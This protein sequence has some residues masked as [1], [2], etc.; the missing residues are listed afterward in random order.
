MFSP[1]NIEN[2]QEC[3]NFISGKW[4]LPEEKMGHITS[5]FTGQ[6]I[7][8]TYRSKNATVNSAVLSA[9]K[10]QQEW[11]KYSYRDRAAIFLNY[12]KWLIENLTELAKIISN[13][14]GK[15]P[16]EAKDGLLKG[17]E[18]L[19]YAVSIQN[20]DQLGKMTV[21]KG[22]QCEYRREPLGVVAG[23]TPSN[24]P[25][26]VPMWMFPIAIMVGNSFIWKPSE[27][28]AMTAY[29]LAQ[30]FKEAGLPDG[31]LNVIQGDKETVDLLCDHENIKAIAFV[32]STPV[33]KHVYTKATTSGKRALT[34]GGAKNHIFLMPD[35]INE[36]AVEG[37]LSSFTG[38]CGQRCMAASVLLAIG[39]TQKII[40][41]I[42]IKAK[43][44]TPGK[45]IGALITKQS[46]Q[47]VEK[48]ISTASLNKEQILVDGR[49][50]KVEKELSLGNWL[51]PTI[52]DY[53]LPE[54]ILAKEELFAP[55]LSIIRCKNIEEAMQIENANPY[56]NAASVFTTRGDIAEFV[57]L[58]A[59]AGMIGINVGIPVPR[60]PFS[61]GGINHSKFGH[62]D[63][64][65]DGG[66][67][68]WSNRKKVTTKWFQIKNQNWMS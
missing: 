38:C 62:G 25:A 63:I 11:E 57:T 29:Y 50:P 27:K 39:D 44:F 23:I 51:N 28:T 42:I 55:V 5:P 12:R 58:N 20:L 19:D 15:L 3:L 24:F 59:R 10:S 35:A 2:I 8:N 14:C 4:E 21:S 18:I 37:I 67:E 65:S 22:V 1:N 17:I 33:A 46:L 47:K 60:E 45:D 52:I 49:N 43:N 54:S 6:I 53:V 13:E 41:D 9:S 68:F 7:A 16:N 30:G 36:L 26:M 64:T 61:F 32:G 56:G 48:A 31:V 34:L 40:E 66:L